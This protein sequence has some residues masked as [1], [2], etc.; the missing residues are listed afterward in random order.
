[1]TTQAWRKRRVFLDLEGLTRW[2]HHVSQRFPKPEKVEIFGLEPGSTGPWDAGATTCFGAVMKEDGLFRLWY[3]GIRMPESHKEQSDLPMTCYAESEDG[4]HWRKPDL[5]ITGQRRYP[6]NNLLS[7]PGVPNGIVRTL[8]GAK[9]KYLATTF[10]YPIPLERDV[11][12]LPGH[13]DPLKGGRGTHVW[14]SD[15]GL[16]WRHVTHVLSLCDN[17]CL[18][19]DLPNNRYLLYNNAMGMH[20][21]TARRMWIGL[22]SKD[23]KHW[24]GYE[25]TH[26]WRETFV[27]DDY[28][29]LRA[30]QNGCLHAEM[31]RVG[32]YRA[33]GI[34]ISLETV[35][36]VGLPVLEYFGA[37]P[38]GTCHTR[39]GFSRDGFKWRYPKGRPN[40]LELGEPGERDGGWIMPTSTLVEHGDDLLFYYGGTRYDHD[41]HMNPDFSL[42]KDIPLEEHRDTCRVMM[43]KMKRDRFASLAAVYKG[44]FDVDVDH[45]MGEEL[46]VNVQAKRGQ[47]RIALAEKW[48]EGYGEVRKHDNLPGYSFDDCVPITGDQVKAPVRFK[49]K[50]VG[51][52]SEGVPLTLRVE[53][54]A[55]EIFGFEW[56]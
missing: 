25:G 40:W 6:G 15:D 7:L 14:E 51:G 37:N 49:E 2:D 9:S 13:P 3:F 11:Q 56:E 33:G 17:A 45:R 53:L 46:F 23:G 21:L 43:A 50:K 55:A 34:L 29:D 5:K 42:R 47:V 44:S 39:L 41:W 28:D 22:E 31:Y 18:H 30:Q 54:T 19:T 12:D 8:P 20:G 48:G 16:H 52:I 10:L 26:R 35:F 27:C 32:I 38:A 24:E 4:I 1:M 36:E